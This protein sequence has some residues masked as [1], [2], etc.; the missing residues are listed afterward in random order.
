MEF[1]E[2]ETKTADGFWLLLEAIV[3]I[4]NPIEFNFKI[5]LSFTFNSGVNCCGAMTSLSG[6]TLVSDFLGGSMITCGARIT[7]RV[8]TTRFE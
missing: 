1:G 8:A 4:L 6:I 2:E 7:G 5:V 3:K